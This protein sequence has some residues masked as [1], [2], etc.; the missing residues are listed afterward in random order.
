MQ[1]ISTPFISLTISN[2]VQGIYAQMIDIDKDM[3]FQMHAGA[4]YLD[5]KPLLELT[6]LAVLIGYLWVSVF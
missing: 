1:K 4:D 5:I 6:S 3:L 2:I